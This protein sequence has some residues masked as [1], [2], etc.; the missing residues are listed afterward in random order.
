MKKRRELK[1]WGAAFQLQDLS[2]DINGFPR[3]GVVG[4]TKLTVST[5]FH[6]ATGRWPD[7]RLFN[8]ITIKEGW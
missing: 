3:I 6:K 5:L 2:V 4:K 7:E 8:K 1:W